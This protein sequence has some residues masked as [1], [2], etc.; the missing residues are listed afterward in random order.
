MGFWTDV[1]EKISSALDIVQKDP[2]LDSFAIYALESIPVV[3]G[4]LVKMYNLSKDPPEDK[5]EQI[6]LLLKKMKEMKDDKLENFCRGLEQ[7]K[8][9][10]LKNQNYL[11]QISNDTSIIINQLEDAKI[12]RR[13]ISQD[14]QRVENKIDKLY[15]IFEQSKIHVLEKSDKH[16]LKEESNTFSNED[17]RISWPSGWEKVD[18]Q[19][20]IQTAKNVDKSTAK[21][22]DLDEISKEAIV[23]RKK[24]DGKRKPN[25]SIVK[26]NPILEIKEY[27]NSLSFF[28]E[29]EFGWN[30]VKINYDKTI[31]I[32]TLEA[33]LNL[34]GIS[35]FTIQK[36]YSRK[37]YSLILTITQLTQDQLDEDPDY[38]TEVREILQ[39]LVFLT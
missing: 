10:I 21:K 29:K 15:E 25:I 20:V 34:F 19:E 8:E 16:E 26:D 39:S 35:T 32:G 7:N 6:L 38:A 5:T 18:E 36:F 37:N 24:T 14:V 1:K 12:E 4:I 2:I 23:L 3:G 11:R 31:G 22:Y 9:L 28:Y 33:E 27:L 13:T 17:F 30:V